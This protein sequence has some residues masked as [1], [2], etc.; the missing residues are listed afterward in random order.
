MTKEEYIYPETDL[1]SIDPAELLC[2]SGGDGEPG[3]DSEYN[4]LFDY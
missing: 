2:G 4:D 1:I 3:S